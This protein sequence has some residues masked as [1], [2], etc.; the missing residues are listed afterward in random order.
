MLGDDPLAGQRAD[1]RADYLGDFPADNYAAAFVDA[2]HNVSRKPMEDMEDDQ[3]TMPGPSRPA[4]M[5]TTRSAEEKTPVRAHCLGVAGPS[6]RQ[7]AARAGLDLGGTAIALV[8]LAVALA[9][10][11]AWLITLLAALALWAAF[12]SVS[13][14]VLAPGRWPRLLTEGDATRAVLLVTLAV[15]ADNAGQ[16]S[17]PVSAA[18]GC[19]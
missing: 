13:T 4:A 6:T 17:W 5:R 10:G 14:T 18:C 11:P 7:I 16:L 8:A 15:T 12:Q 3:A 19:C 9:G 2:V 1:I